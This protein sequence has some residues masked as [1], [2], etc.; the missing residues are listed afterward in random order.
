MR[1][2]ASLAGKRKREDEDEMKVS[3]EIFV[4]AADHPLFGSDPTILSRV[5]PWLTV[6]DFGR[7]EQICRGATIDESHWQGLSERHFRPGMV[8]AIR[9]RFVEKF[10]GYRGLMRYERMFVRKQRPSESCANIPR[11]LP[12]TPL[13]EAPGASPDNVAAHLEV[14]AFGKRRIVRLGGFMFSQVNLFGGGILGS[15]ESS[16]RDPLLV[17]GNLSC[18]NKVLQFDGN[19]AHTNA[20]S[21]G[22][23]DPS[24]C[25]TNWNKNNGIAFRADLEL[26]DRMCS[27]QP[28]LTDCFYLGADLDTTANGS[29]VTIDDARRAV[30]GFTFALMNEYRTTLVFHRTLAAARIQQGFGAAFRN[31]SLLYCPVLGLVDENKV[32]IT[33]FHLTLESF[34]RGIGNLPFAAGLNANQSFFNNLELLHILEEL[35]GV[36]ARSST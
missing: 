29:L 4:S 19:V 25:F 26:P 27:L 18:F 32:G 20:R 12:L 33:G 14:T 22:C 35:E 15:L 16:F 23:D 2:N 6:L 24:C 21:C 30:R 31:L 28:P 11:L 17:L 1:T 34:R 3:G 13:N 7:V 5:C 10:G 36:S 9:L 8:P